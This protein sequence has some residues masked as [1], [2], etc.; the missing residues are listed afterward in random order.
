MEWLNNFN[1]IGIMNN[2]KSTHCK[3][4]IDE[5]FGTFL[6][7][8]ILTFYKIHFDSSSLFDFIEF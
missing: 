2:N 4:T 1:K 3:Y 6:F 7:K 5:L 8:Y